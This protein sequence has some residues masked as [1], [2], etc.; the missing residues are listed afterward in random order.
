LM[1]EALVSNVKIP[2]FTCPECDAEI[3]EETTECPACGEALIR[4]NR[5]GDIVAEWEY[6]DDVFMCDTC[7]HET[8]NR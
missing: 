5:C 3:D 4:C 7:W 6:R 1:G 8:L 2:A